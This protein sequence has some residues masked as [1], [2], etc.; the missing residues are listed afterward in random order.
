MYSAKDFREWRKQ[1]PYAFDQ[2]VELHSQYFPESFYRK[3]E[4]DEDRCREFLTLILMDPDFE[5]AVI[6]WA[7]CLV[8]FS[9]MAFTSRYCKDEYVFGDSFYVDARHRNGKCS[10][11]L[12]D[13][14][15]KLCYS[16]GAKH[17]QLQ[18]AA[19]F[20]DNGRN[21]R[22]FRMLCKRNQFRVI[23]STLYREF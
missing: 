8:G 20:P 15:I 23:G 10:Q 19:G 22:A 4:W 14:S 7:G 6:E 17:F 5:I 3:S 21:E 18:S 9:I 11:M 12:L 13:F 16:R 2:L 1:S